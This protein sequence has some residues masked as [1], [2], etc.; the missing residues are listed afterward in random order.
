MELA[1]NT[2]SQQIRWLALEPKQDVLSY[3]G[4]GIGRYYYNTC[5]HDSRSTTQ[6]NSVMVEAESL[7]MSTVND[8]NPI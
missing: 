7:H 1:R 8:K 4:F 6:N 3:N 2:I 5:D